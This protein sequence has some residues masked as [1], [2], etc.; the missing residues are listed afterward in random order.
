M[1]MTRHLL[2]GV[3]GEIM[4][5]KLWFYA[6]LNPSLIPLSTPRPLKV[7]TY[8]KVAAAYLKWVNFSDKF[9]TKT[10]PLR[11]VRGL[12]KSLNYRPT[13]G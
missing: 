5:R 11:R 13:A 4:K 8:R 9:I 1:V 2:M 12:I 10:S 3:T 7:V 6:E